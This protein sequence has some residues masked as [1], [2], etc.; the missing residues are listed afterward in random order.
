MDWQPG[1][2]SEPFGAYMEPL[3]PP[4]QV[5]VIPQDIFDD[6]GDLDTTSS[7]DTEMDLDMDMGPPSHYMRDV[8]IRESAAAEGVDE[9]RPDCFFKFLEEEFRQGTLSSELYQR[10]VYKTVEFP[11][12]VTPDVL[13]EHPILDK[14]GLEWG[15]LFESSRRGSF[16]IPDGVCESV[17]THKAL[18][19]KLRYQRYAAYRPPPSASPTI[20]G[21]EHS[22]MAFQRCFTNPKPHLFHFQLR[23]LMYPVSATQVFYNANHMDDFQVD[24]LN[25]ETGEQTVAISPEMCDPSLQQLRVSALAANR[26]VVMLGSTKGVFVVKP[27]A[28]TSSSEKKSFLSSGMI[29]SGNELQVNY[30]SLLSSSALIS[31][32]DNILRTLDL[33]TLKAKDSITLNYAANATAFLPGSENVCVMACDSQ[34]SHVY[35]SR[36]GKLQMSLQGHTDFGFACAWSPDGKTVAT[37]NQDGTCRL[38]DIRGASNQCIGAVSGKLQAAIRSVDFDASG[39]YLAIAEPVDY[40][41]VI[42]TWS[43]CTSRQ[44]IEF[45]GGTAGVRFTQSCSLGEYQQLTIGVADETVGGVIQYMRPSQLQGED[46]GFI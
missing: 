20:Q 45:F 43:E 19:R 5:P 18:V 34:E 6:L 14:Q 42:D 38:Y 40:V 27:L 26:N 32:N 35:D 12:T 2:P 30:I 13:C 8:A 41:T 10:S 22:L 7:H 16:L 23:N 24:M 31:G 25:P 36:S 39:R 21:F 46:F 28:E 4:Y 33:N 9:D 17:A 29:S 44:T 1:Y 3:D 37:G 11:D 15:T